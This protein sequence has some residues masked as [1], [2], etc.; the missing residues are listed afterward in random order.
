[1][2]IDIKGYEVE[3]DKVYRLRVK[4]RVHTDGRKND[5]RGKGAVL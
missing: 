1:M 3:F 2:V 5:H 4:P